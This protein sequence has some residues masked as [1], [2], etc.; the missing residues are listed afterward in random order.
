MPKSETIGY[1]N[2]FCESH[3][4]IQT[5]NLVFTL[6]LPS[7]DERQTISVKVSNLTKRKPS[8]VNCLMFASETPNNCKAFGIA[9]TNRRSTFVTTIASR[10]LASTFR[11]SLARHDSRSL[12]VFSKTFFPR[13]VSVSSA[14]Q[15]CADTCPKAAESCELNLV[16]SIARLGEIRPKSQKSSIKSPPECACSALTR[17]NRKSSATA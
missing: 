6:L 11:K 1:E 14:R 3:A 15:R 8:M 10:E 2:I 13:T 17:W 5:P 12:R 9:A 7:T 16:I 4:S